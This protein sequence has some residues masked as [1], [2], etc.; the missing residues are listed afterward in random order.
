MVATIEL[1]TLSNKSYCMIL[2]RYNLK[3]INPEKVSLPDEFVFELPERVLQFGTGVLLRGLPDYFID[4]ANR[5]GIFNGRIVVVKSTNSGDTNAFDRQDGLYTVCVRGLENGVRQEENIVNASI[6][7]VLAAHS[8]WDKIL[9]CAHNPQLQVIISNTTEVGIQ[10]LTTDDIRKHPPISFPGKLLAFLFERYHAFGGSEQSG[11]IIIPTELIPDNGRKLEAIVLELAHLNGLDVAFIEWLENKNHFC[12]SLVDRIVPGRPEKS[13]QLAIEEELGYQDDLLTVAET[14]RLWA[15]EGDDKIRNML[16]FAK[17]DDGVKVEPNINLYRELKLRLLNG[18]HT[19]SCCLAFLAQC[20]TVKQAMDDELISSFISELMFS[21]LAVAIPYKIDPGQAR[22]FGMKVLD[23]FRNPHIQHAWSSITVQVSSKM[24][25]RNIPILVQHYRQSNQ[26]PP[27]FAL[28]FAAYL[29]F[30]K[31]VKHENG[32]YYGRMKDQF[33]KIQ[34][35]MAPEFYKRWN[36]L[37]RAKLVEVVLSDK[38]FWGE[39]LSA[40]P[41]FSAAVQEQLDVISNAGLKEAIEPVL[42]KKIAV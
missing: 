20:E 21:E 16:S 40:L 39:D 15:I 19:L 14:Y 33:Y 17:V 23:R 12:S 11:M 32:Q 8:D 7:R 22:A 36:N 4:K 13:F 34:D 41:G 24:K 1:K 28:G 9:E 2:S 25:L 30:M 42:H 3:N 37:Q 6:S 10:L 29:Y 18:T 26:H 27:L 5:A 38:A 31:A 35:D